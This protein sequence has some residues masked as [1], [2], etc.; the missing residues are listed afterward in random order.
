MYGR[1]C[2]VSVPMEIGMAY[3]VLILKTFT[4]GIG[5]LNVD[6]GVNVAAKDKRIVYSGTFQ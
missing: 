1:Q 2:D 6:V 3:G 5:K 4:V